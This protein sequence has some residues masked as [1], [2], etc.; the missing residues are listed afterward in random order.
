MLP[1]KMSEVI[2]SE[3]KMSEVIM[4]EVIMPKVKMSEVQT[5]CR[6]K[7]SAVIKSQHFIVH[8]VVT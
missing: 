3:V 1:G 2:L 7:I 6:D 5:K 8:N 4:S